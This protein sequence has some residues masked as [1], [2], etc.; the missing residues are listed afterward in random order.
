MGVFLII[1]TDFLYVWGIFVLSTSI[2]VGIFKKEK[3]SRKE[4]GYV[5]IDV[6]QNYKL[7]W[8]ILKLPRMKTLL[9]AL[10]TMKVKCY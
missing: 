4:N 6:F 9:F 8:D 3:D 7:I 10:L 5:K 2:L 1:F